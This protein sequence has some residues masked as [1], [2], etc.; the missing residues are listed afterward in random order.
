[1]K[2][3][4]ASCTHCG[5]PL[6]LGEALRLVICAYCNATMAIAHLGP[7]SEPSLQQVQ[8]APADVERIK[9]LV[10]DGRRD[11]AIAHCA[12]VSGVSRDE[13]A[14]TVDQLLIPTVYE[15]ARGMPINAFGFAI[16]L[17]GFGLG[18]AL[19]AWGA[20]LVLEESWGGVALVLLGALL[21]YG[22][23]RYLVPKAIATWI[24]SYGATGRAAVR[25]RVVLRDDFARGG[26]LLLVLFEVIPDR[27]GASFVDQEAI[28]VRADRVARLEVGNVVRVRFDEPG[29]TRV[30]P[31]S[32]IEVVGRA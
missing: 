8:V 26:V 16:G 2:V 5:A 9:R 29:R 22:G 23:V 3:Q 7:A 27:G 4:H 30:F 19:A 11:E 12:S 32:P 6:R 20:S 31:V 15:L 13:A 10:L 14:A 25:R 21:A 18:L 24:S 17:G 28:L 1:M